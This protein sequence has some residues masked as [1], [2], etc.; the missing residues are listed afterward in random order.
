MRM[1]LVTLTGLALLAST[2]AWAQE[3]VVVYEREY[4]F[5][6][7]DTNG[8]GTISV[9]EAKAHPG[10]IDEAIHHMF[11]KAHGDSVTSDTWDQPLSKEDWDGLTSH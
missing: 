5:S 3:T 10:F 1:M 2:V 6:D 9:D 11:V 8:D 7:V 4:S